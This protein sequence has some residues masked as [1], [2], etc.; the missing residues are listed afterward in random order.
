MPFLRAPMTHRHPIL[1]FVAA[2][3]VSLSTA[4]GQEPP[5]AYSSLTKL[6]AAE[7]M[8]D[9]LGKLKKG[10]FDED[11]GKFLETA[12]LPQLAA[13]KNRPTIERVRR[14]LREL[15]LGER[16]TEAA[17][18]E[19]ANAVAAKALVAMARDAKADLLVRV[20]AMLLVGELTGKD[21]KPWSGGVTP[22]VTAAADPQ[23]DMGVRVAA[24]AG[25]ARRIDGQGG[26]IGAEA[27]PKLLAIVA[28]PPGKGG[29]GSDWLVSRTLEI[30]PAA[31]PAATP[32]AAGTL[33]SLL[34][35]EAR[36]I[37]VRVRAAA[38]L[39]AMATAEAKIDVGRALAAIRG[40]AAAALTADLAAAEDRAL[41]R[42][43]SGQ[44]PGGMPGTMPGMPT[45][46]FGG[47]P[48]QFGMGGNAVAAEP[49]ATTPIEALVVQRDAWRL[50]TLGDAVG[51]ADGAKGLVMLL[52]AAGK[53]TATRLAKD[54]RDWAD[55]LDQTPD[56][57][58]MK[59]AIAALTK[60]GQQPAG[61]PQPKPAAAKPAEEP[62]ATDIFSTPAN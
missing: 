19:K 18:L 20:N 54:L 14:R 49:A 23:L 40:I 15:A 60:V 46:E 31:L 59:Q 47:M 12:I 51:S 38:A 53:P 44:P 8:R 57:A 28:A 5:A 58:T 24:I 29:A 25:L 13:E 55:A 22:L 11:A 45:G 37:D 17:A 50:A 2:F 9:F 27:A 56:A 36:A 7:E 6:E 16:E 4:R 10:E 3:A 61:A 26:A 32:A 35:D 30:L 48:P 42:D 21:G 52:P 41:G 33:L 62:A 43:L 39:G 1:A 34:E